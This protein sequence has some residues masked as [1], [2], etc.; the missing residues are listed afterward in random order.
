MWVPTPIHG[1]VVV[2]STEYILTH[3]SLLTISSFFAQDILFGPLLSRLRCP[4][5]VTSPILCSSAGGHN[6]QPRQT[7]EHWPRPVSAMTRDTNFDSFP[8]KGVGAMSMSA[9]TARRKEV[10]AAK[11]CP[12]GGT[13]GHEQGAVARID[14]SR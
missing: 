3:H 2:P 10:D 4:I 13:P 11:G 14:Q 5:A 9:N 8:Q 6:K 1:V 12:R 7:S